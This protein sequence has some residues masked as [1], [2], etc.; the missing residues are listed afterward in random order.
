MAVKTIAQRLLRL[1]VAVFYDDFVQTDLQHSSLSAH[2]LL[3]VFCKAVG[4]R[5]F[6]K[7][8]KRKLFSHIA[9]GVEFVLEPSQLVIR[10]T[11]SR[12]EEITADRGQTISSCMYIVMLSGASRLGLERYAVVL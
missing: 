11:Q 3:E 7:L 2:I 4:L 8:Q 1:A 12:V 10:N 9:L 5:F 6:R